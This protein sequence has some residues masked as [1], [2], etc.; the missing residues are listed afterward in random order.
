[1]CD[2]TSAGQR[3]V[4]NTEVELLIYYKIHNEWMFFTCC[5]TVQKNISET[6]FLTLGVIVTCLGFIQLLRAICIFNICKHSEYKGIFCQ[7]IIVLKNERIKY[8]NHNKGQTLNA[9]INTQNNVFN[10]F[11][12]FSVYNKCLLYFCHYYNVKQGLFTLM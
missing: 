5:T 10:S 11:N 4:K 8:D 7:R 3:S 9:F 12:A 2:K 1:M 6:Y